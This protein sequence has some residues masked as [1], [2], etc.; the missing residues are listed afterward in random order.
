MKAYHYEFKDCGGVL[1]ILAP[2]KKQAEK[3]LLRQ[4]YDL[5]EL[6]LKGISTNLREFCKL[7]EV[8]YD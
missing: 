7:S 8:K 5:N 6:R 1:N 3:E 4:K 2:S